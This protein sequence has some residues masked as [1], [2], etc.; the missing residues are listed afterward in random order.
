MGNKSRDVSGLSTIT[1]WK[2]VIT[3]GKRFKTKTST[4]KM[5]IVCSSQI[6]RMEIVKITCLKIKSPW[7]SRGRNKPN[8]LYN[9]Q[10]LN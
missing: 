9:N 3:K 1:K 7:W 4:L 10:T 6:I 5:W 2:G 8:H